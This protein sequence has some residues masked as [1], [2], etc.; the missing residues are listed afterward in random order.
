MPIRA[1]VFDIGGVLELT[2]STGWA[3]KWEA[4]LN[5]RPGELHTRLHSVWSAGSIG[6]ISE[7]DIHT[8]IGEITGMSTAQVDGL[9]AD[10]WD[11]YLGTLN[12]E[13]ADYFG[14]LRPRYRTAIISNSF[15]GAREKEQARY[16]FDELC[17]FIIYSHEVGLEKPGR[18]IFE[19]TC[20]RLGMQFADVIFLDDFEPHVNAARELGMHAI[21][22]QSTA[23][24]IADI[25]AL[26]LASTP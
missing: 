13:L 25:E 23:Q 19:I 1:V 15:V 24:A 2:A 11:E 4:R 3:E 21:L 14:S 7:A 12:V 26:L 9:M 17:D 20:E 22:F 18:Q 5:L 16:H 6:A 8:R 10:L